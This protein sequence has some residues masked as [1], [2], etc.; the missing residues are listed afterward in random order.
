[1]PR[2]A[3]GAGRPGALEEAR[4]LVALVASLSEA[5][6]ALTVEAVSSRLG[7]S[8]ERAETLI[9]LVLT[10]VGSDGTR[11]PLVEDAGEVT[12]AF[13]QGMRGRRLRLTRPETIALE[14][15]LEHLGVSSEDPLRQRLEESTSR[16]PVDRG[17]VERL[18]GGRLDGEL[19]DT[20]A[21][22][23]QALALRRGLAFAYRKSP[24]GDP[25][26]RRVTPRALRHEEGSWYLDAYDTD[27]QGERTFRLDRMSNVESRPREEAAHGAPADVRTVE[28]TFSDPRYVDM[29]PWHGLRDLRQGDDGKMVG[30]IDY[31]GGM[32]LPHMVAA[33]AGTARVDD[34][35]VSSRARNYAKALLGRSTTID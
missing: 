24:E 7:V 4:E 5:G 17:L 22:C 3:K 19:G 2:R 15:A 14:A 26:Q 29:L 30:N 11:L 32:W 9:E 8:A 25:E 33:C 21:S 16:E 28:I 27:R 1:M 13:S 35:E 6:D 23:A 31:F 34:P 10:S 20:V 18:V 12:L